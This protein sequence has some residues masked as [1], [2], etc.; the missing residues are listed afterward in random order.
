MAYFARPE[1]KVTGN[2]TLDLDARKAHLLSVKTDRPSRAKASVLSFSRTWDDTWIHSGSMTGGSLTNAVYAD[3]QGAA[4]NGTWEFGTWSRRYA[5]AV[6]SMTVKGG[7]ALHPIAA[8]MTVAG[9]DGAGRAPLVDAG[10]G[11]RG[12]PHGRAGGGQG[13]P[14]PAPRVRSSLTSAMATLAREAG[15]KALLLYRPVAG[16]WVPTMGSNPVSISAYALPLEEGEQLAD[17][18]RRAPGGRS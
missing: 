13:R 7:P 11:S 5:P 18:L 2:M 1:L 14:R 3:I 4:K 17:L 9:L 12:R 15:A 8:E 10:T 16:R 6:Q